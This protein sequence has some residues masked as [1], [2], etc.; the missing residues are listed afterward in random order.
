MERNYKHVRIPNDT[1]DFEIPK[2]VADYIKELE[3]QMPPKQDSKCTCPTIKRPL[4][5]FM[6]EPYCHSCR[7][8]N[9]YEKGDFEKFPRNIK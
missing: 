2:E 1:R 6:P 3:E 8:Y 7:D 5:K 4:G 9:E